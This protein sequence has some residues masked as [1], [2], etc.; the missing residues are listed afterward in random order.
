MDSQFLESFVTVVES[1]SIAEAARRLDL[2]AAGVAQRIRALEREIGARLVFRSG[3]NVR[4][5]EAGVA[6]LAYAR[7]L[8][9]R[10][11]DLKSIA[12]AGE[13][14]GELRLGAMH[15]AL[16]GVLPDI[17]SLMMRN[18]P[19]IRVH[20]SQ[21]GSH[22]LYYRVLNEE[23]DAAIISQPPFTIPKTCGW[24]VLR[25]EPLVVL[26][27]AETSVR[28]PHK[29][30]ASEPFIR[31]ERNSWAGRLIDGY[32]RHVNIRPFERFE[33]YQQEA[34]AGMVDRGLGVSLVPDWAP[35]W[36]SGLSLLKLSL[37]SNPFARRVGLLWTKASVRARLVR[38]VLEMAALAPTL[39]RK[40][41]PVH[42]PGRRKA[43]K[44]AVI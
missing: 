20:I 38:A 7:E 29:L 17:L 44:N 42:E 8:L 33:I 24:R 28:N 37:P 32:L 2:T 16:A 11:R 18:Y 41:G 6:I 4:A 13:L 12:T 34:I 21:G 10:I 43:Q 9:R 15:T 35:P 3:R 31:M 40:G 39:G 27:P 5:T 19:R 22:E 36:P 14:A 26:A 25:V 30:L 23:L 1:G